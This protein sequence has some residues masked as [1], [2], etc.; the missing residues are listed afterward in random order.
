M[1]NFEIIN[2]FEVE[3]DV[4]KAYENA[5]KNAEIKAK[6]I[7]ENVKFDWINSVKKFE[8]KLRDYFLFKKRSIM[9]I[10]IENIMESKQTAL[11]KDYNQQLIEC[12]KQKNIIP[13]LELYQAAYLEFT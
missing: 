6:E 9:N 7:Y 13:N 3:V 10:Q 5:F 8:D 11:E 12:E 4:E 2:N 1:D